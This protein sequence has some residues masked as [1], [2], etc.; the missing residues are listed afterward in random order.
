MH[1]EHMTDTSLI[2]RPSEGEGEGEGRPGTHCMRMRHHSP[3]FGES[4]CVWIYSLYTFTDAFTINT[5][6]CIMASL[7]VC[8]VQLPYRRAYK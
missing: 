7:L 5:R 4:E 8:I 6:K 2:P 1:T 3:D